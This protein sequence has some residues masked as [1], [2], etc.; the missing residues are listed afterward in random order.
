MNVRDIPIVALLLR[1]DPNALNPVVP[2]VPVIPPVVFP[3]YDPGPGIDNV[4]EETAM[5][6]FLMSELAD[7]VAP[8][9]NDEE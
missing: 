5:E 3:P 8:F 1:N 2:P 7:S 4:S 6:D 9:E